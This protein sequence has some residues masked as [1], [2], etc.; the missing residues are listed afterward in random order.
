MSIAFAGHIAVTETDYGVVLLD[1]RHGRYW[2][3]NPTAGLVVDI[4]RAGGTEQDAVARVVGTFDVDRERASADVTALLSAM[5][6][7]GVIAR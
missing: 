5:R 7:A 6:A 4:L 2:K 1:Q 3:L